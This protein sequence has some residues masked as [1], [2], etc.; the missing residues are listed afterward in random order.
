MSP[1]GLFLE[2]CG[3][4]WPS[5]FLGVARKRDTLSLCTLWKFLVAMAGNFM[6]LNRRI[7]MASSRSGGTAAIRDLSLLEEWEKKGKPLYIQLTPELV[8]EA[9]AWV[10]KMLGYQKASRLKPEQV[11]QVYLDN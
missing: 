2:L 1:F 10:T 11:V 9:R 4:V 7:I 5:H 6:D 8:S 3:Q